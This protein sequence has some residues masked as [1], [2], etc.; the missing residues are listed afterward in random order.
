MFITILTR[1]LKNEVAL[2]LDTQNFIECTK[3]YGPHFREDQL[4]PDTKRSHA[5]TGKSTCNS[6]RSNT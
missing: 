3:I 2:S 6:L 5:S 4:T 1:S